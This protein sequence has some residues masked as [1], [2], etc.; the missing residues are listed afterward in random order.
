MRA[1][2]LLRGA[3]HLVLAAYPIEFRRAVGPAMLDDLDRGWVTARRDG[4]MPAASRFALRQLADLVRNVEREWRSPSG[5]PVPPKGHGGWLRGSL[6]DL[7]FAARSLRRD[8]M[9]AGIVVLVVGLGIGAVVT[10]YGMLD[11]ILL[12]PPPYPDAERIVSVVESFRADQVTSASYQNFLD[13]RDR[14]RAF[15]S[16]AA[17]NRTGLVLSGE[18]SARMLR[19]HGASAELFAL[20]GIEMLRGRY[21]TRQE[22]DEA[23]R[24]AVVGEG[25]W[26]GTFGEADALVGRSLRL[27]GEPYT[28]VGVAPALP[29]LPFD[30]AELWIPLT[31]AIGPRSVQDRTNHPG[32]EAFGRLRE[33]VTYERGVED[34]DR[35]AAG[36]AQEYPD[37]NGE[38][39][40][41][42][43]PLSSRAV[44]DAGATLWVLLAAVVLVMAGVCANVASLLLARATRRGGEIAVRSALGAGRARMARQLLAE[45]LLLSSAAGVVGLGVAWLAL[46]VVRN[47]DRLQL[48]RLATVDIDPSV[49]FFAVGAATL[50]G[51]LFASAPAL[52]MLRIDPA[53]SLRSAVG[54][55]GASSSG[56][57]GRSALV[58]AQVALAVTLLSGAG[59]MV[60]TLANLAGSD[61]GIDPGNV[62]TAY[63]VPSP[64]QYASAEDRA[65][66][67]RD[68]AERVATLPGVR[69][70]SGGDPLPMSGH[71]SFSTLSNDGF[72]QVDES[73]LRVDFMNVMP[74]YFDVMGIE[75]LAGRDFGESDGREAPVA[76]VD[77]TL[78]RF[79]WPDGE[80]VGNR[81]R[82]SGPAEG[83]PWF[84]V[85]GVVE[86]V[87]NAGVRNESRHELYLP[88]TISV[89]GVSILVEL[90]PGLEPA[91]IL[92]GMRAELAQLDP[93]VPLS[94][95]GTVRGNIE[96]S[97]AAEAV[98]TRTLGGF[99]AATLLVAMIGLYG[100][101]AYSVA[102]RSREFGIRM[103]LGARQVRV[104]G[105]VLREGI[106]LAGGG[107]LLGSLGALIAGRWLGSLLYGVESADPATLATVAL[108]MTVVSLLATVLPARRAVRVDPAIA[109]RE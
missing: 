77:E 18:G 26:R 53:V 75:L 90:E 91:S 33:G 38:A 56:R 105:V 107:V 78:A 98:V 47:S 5:R 95:I 20:F 82:F 12:E 14:N 34:L 15:E 58:V 63:V 2:R 97:I 102:L 45:G 81:V 10:V 100:V 85:V 96:R 52:R 108:V 36:L 25:L 86:H 19:G 24:V 64:A 11:A 35:V 50:A 42:V 88:Y 79:L 84:T 65:R 48:P 89:W 43:R 3:C 70:V 16:F 6:Q 106:L 93:E 104:L 94:R 92:D 21:F 23:A 87:K 71:D 49:A 4:G 41:H 1:P 28:I 32:I 59:L 101:I 72:P 17:R 74:G 29:E 76:I 66:L 61:T 9:F 39:G 40:V 46:G 51:L 55:R 22:V 44:G 73:G 37:T 99:A 62:L 80:A 13:W 8:P 69:A 31:T 83:N 30:D 109:L 54:S 103:A 68:F 60:R 7:R 57:Y 67:Y 27:D